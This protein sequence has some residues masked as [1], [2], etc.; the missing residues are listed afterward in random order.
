MMRRCAEYDEEVRGVEGGGPRISQ[1]LGRFAAGYVN[2]K[3][4]KN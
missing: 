3:L 1:N 4:S 2:I